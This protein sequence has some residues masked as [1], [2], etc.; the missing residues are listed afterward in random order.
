MTTLVSEGA[1]NERHSHSRTGPGAN[2][3]LSDLVLTFQDDR[4]RLEFVNIIDEFKSAAVV[5]APLV[6]IPTRT[7]SSVDSLT[8]PS[9]R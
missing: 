2:E 5:S 1:V 8:S 3:G 9:M 4:Y 7:A 6:R